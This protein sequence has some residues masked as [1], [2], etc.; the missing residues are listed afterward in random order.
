MAAEASSLELL[1]CG[2]LLAGFVAQM[3]ELIHLLEQFSSFAVDLK[4]FVDHLRAFILCCYPSLDEV[5]VLTNQFQAQHW[6]LLPA[7]T[8]FRLNSTVWR[9][10]INAMICTGDS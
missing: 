10:K 1:E 9:P 8:V 7:A 4:D 3:L 2:N 6:H 5:R